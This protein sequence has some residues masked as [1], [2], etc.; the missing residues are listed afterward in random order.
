MKNLELKNLELKNLYQ[1]IDRC[2]FCKKNRNP[3]Q[4]IHGYGSIRP[5]L[6][7]IL[8][9]PTYRNVSSAPGYSGLR[10]PFIGVRHFWKVLADGGL[11]NK[12]IGY[13]LPP[14][15]A[16]H[17]KHT[18]ATQKELFKNKLFLTN[19]VKC[20]YNHPH[21]PEKKI[22]QEQL[23]FLKKELQIV[24]PKY[25]IAF[26]GLVYKVLTGKNIVLS[27][28]WRNSSRKKEALKEK[29]SGL[30]IPVI[31]SYYPIARGNPKKA[32]AILRNIK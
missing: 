23:Q 9:N 28:Y 17:L 11:I 2:I 19:I 32:A 7:L 5:R 12:K 25:I 10:F 3:L 30:A 29:I 21:Y 20:C 14:R 15:S 22:I 31:P 8:I 13:A 6:M 26:G 24:K 18:E 4:H 1:K 27:K 16:W